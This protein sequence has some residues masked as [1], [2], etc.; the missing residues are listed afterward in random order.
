MSQLTDRDFKTIAF[1]FKR[2]FGD[3]HLFRNHF[4]T[5]TVPLALI[6]FKTGR[7]DW[8]TVGRRCAAERQHG[9]LRDPLCR[10]PQ[11]LALLYLGTYQ[12][13]RHAA[14]ALNTLGN[15]RVELNAGRHLLA[16]SPGDYFRGDSEPWLLFLQRQI[17]GIEHDPA[18]PGSL[19]PF[20]RAGLL[21]TRWQIAS[22]EG[23][24]AASSLKQTLLT[25]LPY[26]M[27]SDGAA[28]WS[29]W[30]GGELF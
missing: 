22:E 20:P 23:N 18:M 8:E 11:G 12:P 13:E 27:L 25:E 16:G 28:D 9:R 24:P 5:G 3:V 7:L 14:G 30:A 19:R 6:G 15:V 4:K 1:T 2:A 17:E 26:A 21:A 29:F 10:Y